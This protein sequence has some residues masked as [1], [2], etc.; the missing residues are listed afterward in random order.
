VARNPA[1]ALHTGPFLTE[2]LYADWSLIQREQLTQM[3]LTM[4]RALSLHALDRG[5]FEEVLTWSTM[6]LQEN[7]CDEAAYRLLMRAYMATGRRAEA[8]RLYQRCAQTLET[9][10]G[11]HPAPE[12]TILFNAIVNYTPLPGVDEPGA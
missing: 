8:L 1:C 7:R 11:I 5:N 9:E 10:L 4:C 6:M 12:T 3:Y 2:D